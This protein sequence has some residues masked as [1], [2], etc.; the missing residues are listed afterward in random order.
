[1]TEEQIETYYSALQTAV[2][3]LET[4]DADTPLTAAIESAEAIDLTE[5]EDAGKEAFTAALVKAKAAKESGSISEKEAATAELKEAMNALVKKQPVVPD[6]DAEATAAL[7]AAIESA[8][9]IDLAE[10]EDAGK[11]AFTAALAKARAAKASGSVSEKEA[12]TA[13]LNEAMSALVKKAPPQNNDDWKIALIVVG[14]SIA[15]VAVVAVA[16]IMIRKKKSSKSD[17][18]EDK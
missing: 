13:E 4:K 3:A 18:R 6:G 11:E 8:E 12:A 16:V 10:Y 17:N 7:T 15:V 9:A 1:M 14:A 2:Q 5:Y